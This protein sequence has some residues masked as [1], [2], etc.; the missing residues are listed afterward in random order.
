MKKGAQ[1]ILSAIVIIILALS[2]FDIISR[3]TALVLFGLG[4]LFYFSSIAQKID[5]V[6]DELGINL[7]EKDI[8]RIMPVSYK[9]DIS[10][11][12]DWAAVIKECFPDIKDNKSAWNF[13][14]SLYHDDELDI[15][16][17]ASL[18]QQPISFFDFTMFRD[19]LSGLEQVWSKHHDHFVND[20][21][22]R[23][24]VFSGSWSALENKFKNN[25]ISTDIFIAPDFIAFEHVLP[26]GHREP[27][28]TPHEKD[29]ISK[30]PFW[31]VFH[32]IVK[33][34]R[35]R[36]GLND[37]LEFSEKLRKEIQ[38]LGVTFDKDYNYR[39]GG[40]VYSLKGKL[41]EVNFSINFFGA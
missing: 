29:K 14:D 38:S 7:K 20:L 5:S 30:I 21:L 10:I 31:E 11:G 37:S 32:E 40:Y 28:S 25:P 8:R 1:I 16:K 17:D 9:L 41:H 12:V 13:V 36:K 22:I 34:N 18:Y 3:T 24:K 33:F 4:L 39:Q 15:D 26:G 35:T 6:L 19:G 2:Y 27:D 23:G